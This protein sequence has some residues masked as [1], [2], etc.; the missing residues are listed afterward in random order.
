M[1]TRGQFHEVE[2]NFF[3]T[4]IG[5]N[6]FYSIFSLQNLG[7]RENL[8]PYKIINTYKYIYRSSAN[9]RT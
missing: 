8:P 9:R 4:L 6:V 2:C 7:L 5:L 1:L 3:D